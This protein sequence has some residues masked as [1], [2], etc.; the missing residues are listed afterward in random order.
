MTFFMMFRDNFKVSCQM[1]LSHKLRSILSII[2][3]VFGILAL[4][5][6]LAIGEGTRRKIMKTVESMGA[7]LIYVSARPTLQEGGH[8]DYLPLTEA[9]GERLSQLKGIS[10]YAPTLSSA[11]LMR[12]E[13]VDRAMTVE[14]VTSSYQIVRELKMASGRFLADQDLEN[15]K[16][17]VV[18]GSDLAR[19]LFHS[20][21]PLRQ[22]LHIWEGSFQIVGVLE[23]KGRTVGVDFDH[24]ILMPLSSLQEIQGH[25]R[26]IQGIW[27][28]AQESDL[29]QQ[30][31]DQTRRLLNRQDIEIWNQEALLSQKSRMTRA[32]QWALGAIAFVSLLIGGIGMM[33]VLLVSVA[34]RVK[35][36]GLRKAVGATSWDILFQFIFESLF[37]TF[38]GAGIGILLG[39]WV[40]DSVAWSLNVWLP[41]TERWEA[42]FSWNTVGAALHFTLWMGL[43][44]GLYPASKASRLDPCEALSYL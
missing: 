29:T 34:E 7:N 25:F 35:E 17:V 2:G 32:F 41:G 26:E 20:Q 28:R 40:G 4:L 10:A 9:E 19:E 37:L 15:Q 27:I 22:I 31:M 1:L 36:I 12:I 42:V 18:I 3:I 8:L 39:I 23:K 5:V 30:V 13:N 14:G 43:I 11:L 16:R 24:Q 38:M 6:T 21:N 33:N 44:F